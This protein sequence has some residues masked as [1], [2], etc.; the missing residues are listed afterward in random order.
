M[1]ESVAAGG[2]ASPFE[3]EDAASES[4]GGQL[5]VTVATQ[6]HPTHHHDG[7]MCAAHMHPPAGRP[8][9]RVLRS[10]LSLRGLGIAT[11][12]RVGRAGRLALPVARWPPQAPAC[13]WILHRDVR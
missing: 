10:T 7:I 6:W 4:R 11:G 12:T 2:A 3:L 8:S 9:G 13:Q 5:T 1:V